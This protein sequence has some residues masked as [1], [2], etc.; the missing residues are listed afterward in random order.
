MLY[1]LWKEKK[2]FDTPEEPI[3]YNKEFYDKTESR[4]LP[5]QCRRTYYTDGSGRLRSLVICES[6]GSQ[7]LYHNH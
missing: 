4:G 1:W 7:R 6:F 5:P 3:A 2:E